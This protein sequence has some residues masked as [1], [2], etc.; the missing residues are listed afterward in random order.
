MPRKPAHEQFDTLQA[1]QDHAFE[2]FGRHGFEGVSVGDIAK[3]AA[4]SKG[5][6]YWHFHNKVSLYLDCQQRLHALFDQYIFNPMRAE[7]D[8]VKA[9]LALFQGLERLVRDR[10][11]QNGIAG[12]WLIPSTPET[13]SI[14]SAQRAFEAAA[15]S[16]VKSALEKGREQKKLDVGSELDELAR[17]IITIVEAGVLPLRDQDPDQV[18]RT[19]GVLARTLFRAYASPDLLKL[20]K[21][22]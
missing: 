4:L 10:R 18:H 3:R 12:Y 7:Q 8:A 2:L 14:I 20:A 5:A 1:I 6:M 13:A 22:L 11:V 21:K 17:A 19:L 9:I 15:M 16:T